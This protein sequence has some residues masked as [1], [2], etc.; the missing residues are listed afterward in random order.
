M[1]LRLPTLP[2]IL[3]LLIAITLSADTNAQEV[4]RWKFQRGQQLKYNVQ[5]NMETVMN[6]GGNEIQ[7]QMKMQMDIVWNILGVAAGGDATMDQIVTRAQIKMASGPENEDTFDTSKPEKTENLFLNSMGDV[8]L[9]IVNQNFTITMKPTGE[10]DNVEIPAE[11]LE[12]I[13]ASA[14]GNPAALSESTLKDMMKQSAVTMPPNG[15]APKGT[16][17]SKQSVESPYATINITSTMTFVS[18][19]ADGNVLIDIDPAVMITPKEGAAV[20]MTL[21]ESKGKGQVTF[22]VAQG[23]VTKSQLVMEMTMEID[24]GQRAIQQKVTKTTAMTLVP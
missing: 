8:F 24:S 18:K 11:M 16:W 5:E 21:M 22:N 2:T 9:K 23:V 4:L 3:S 12:A 1:S 6:V 19:D 15:V 7:Q 14:A 13:K 17:T 10:V 20:K